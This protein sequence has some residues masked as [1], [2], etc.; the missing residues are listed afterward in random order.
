MTDL[1]ER[2][3]PLAGPAAFTRMKSGYRYSRFSSQPFELF[4][5]TIERPDCVIANGAGA[6]ARI[7]VDAGEEIGVVIGAH[8]WSGVVEL[9]FDQEPGEAVDLYSWYSWQRVLVLP[10]R[11]R[12]GAW[13]LTVTGRNP[14]SL[15][16]QM[17]LVG[18]L[19][20]KR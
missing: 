19:R 2:P 6:G 4:G 3:R 18:L 20:E 10:R 5:Q 16:E 1:L 17:C 14:A 9:R 15:G 12:V 8:D 13:T 7:P 11:A